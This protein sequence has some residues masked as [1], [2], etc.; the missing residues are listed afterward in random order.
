[1]SFLGSWGC[2]LQ[3]LSFA[4]GI[5]LEAKCFISS[6][7]FTR[8][9]IP[10]H[11]SKNRSLMFATTRR[12]A[13]LISATTFTKLALVRRNRKWW[14][15]IHTQTCLYY[16]QVTRLPLRHEME[17]FQERH[18]HTSPLLIN[19]PMKLSAIIIR[20]INFTSYTQNFIRYSPLK[21]NSIRR[22]N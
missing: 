18:S 7:N 17:S 9:V 11:Y 12:N 13:R 21:F 14:K 16:D 15:L 4:F 1:V 10:I 19:R 6:D 5:I 20:V 3:T 22:R 2:P 8:N